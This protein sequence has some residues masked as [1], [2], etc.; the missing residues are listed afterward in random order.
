[1]MKNRKQPLVF[2]F[3]LATLTCAGV[4]AAEDLYFSEYIEGSS[5]NKALEI[6]NGT[7]TDIDLSA[8]SVAIYFNGSTTAGN[9]ISLNGTLAAGDVFVLAHTSADT[10][11]LT[12]ADQ[13]SGRVS[14]NGDDAVALVKTE[15]GAAVDVI[16][17]I[18]VDPGSEWGSGDT[19]T[20]NNTLRRLESL[21]DGRTNGTDEFDPIQEWQG[22]S[23]DT[24]DG[25]GIYGEGNGETP[26]EETPCGDP[27]TLIHEVQGSGAESPLNGQKVT[28][29]A[30]V[31]G[32]FQDTVTQIGGFFVQEES[33]DY[34]DDAT[35]S[36]GIFIDDHGFGVDVEVGDLVRLDGEAGEYFG[37]TQVAEVTSLKI[38]KSGYRV[39]A[40]EVQLP[41]PETDY[42][43]RVE[44]MLVEIHQS[45]TITDNY[46]LSRYGEVVLSANSR[47]F[48]P[49]SVATPGAEAN[50]VQAAN[51]LNRLVLDDASDLQ[52][53]EPTSYPRA[54]L[55]AANT[56]RT[57]DRVCHL[58]GIMDYGFGV[59]RLQPVIEPKFAHDNRRPPGPTLPGR[60]ALRAASFNV[61]NYFNGN[62]LGGG[63]PTPRGADSPQE[64]ERQRAKIITAIASMDADVIGLME[65]ENDGYGEQSAI[66]DLVNGLNAVTVEGRYGFID[67]G[68]DALGTDAIAVGM[69]YRTDKLQPIG[70]PAFFDEYPFDYGNRPSL[71]QSF[72][73]I[74]SG[75]AFT[76]VVN[77][78]RSKGSC[79]SDGSPNEDQG[80][81]QGCWNATRVLAVETLH[82]WL[83]SNPT[84]VKGDALKRVLLVGDFNSY[85][86]E[87]PIATLRAFGYRNLI[88]TFSGK[89]AYSYVYRG[90]AGY[91]DYALASAPMARRVTGVT[92][93]HINADEPPALDYNLEYKTEHQQQTFYADD[94]FRASDH[95]PVVIELNLAAPRHPGKAA[96]PRRSR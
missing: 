6:Y 8:Y 44:G 9:S 84:E 72:T 49:T 37:Q 23:Q 36:E 95:D 4:Q 71:A 53:A 92:E 35:T 13:T 31:V 17:Q 96:P 62:G 3:A 75:E 11:M 69:I 39:A 67:P 86:M 5:Y 61:L 78:L 2:A 18:G 55:S 70:M 47:L 10:E 40:T 20:Q 76:L 24:F 73:E 59:Y 56:L 54:G 34:D 63:F 80:D 90:E 87:D 25:L 85:A 48:N 50:A 30:V 38:C 60:G 41:Q 77:H 33:R 83:Q 58:K 45:L 74:A 88:K 82:T 89:Q 94:A 27:A 91:L 93:W 65:I 68:V 64:F 66:Q 42:L 1:M 19:G 52:N 14:F 57:G 15:N 12:V 26:V 79:P 51:D 29:E 21:S 16:G 32:D 28:L 22:F 7:D 46:S 43:E 81:G